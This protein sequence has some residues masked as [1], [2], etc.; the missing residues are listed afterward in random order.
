MNDPR[1]TEAE[2]LAAL[3]FKARQ[4]R[5]IR[6]FAAERNRVINRVTLT[7]NAAGYLPALITWAVERLRQQISAQADA[8]IEE[9]NTFKVPCDEAIEKKL[10]QAAS[11]FAAGSIMNV[12]NDRSVKRHM[13]GI[14]SPW[15]LEIE[16]EMHTSVKEAIAR[17]KHQS[18]TI[19]N[20]P[21]E[22]P[23]NQTF[24]VHGPNARVNID[25]IDNS[26]NI[27]NQG[28]PFSELRKA[29]ES[30]V[31]DGIERATILERLA[32]LEMATD[33]ES[34]SKRYQSFI[35]SAHHHMALIG[36]YLPALGH[37]VH[38]LLAAAI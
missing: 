36:P 4:E 5:I 29:I 24:N 34:G 9:F 25:S 13:L 11:D 31:T 20:R 7:Q 26:T 14:A 27:V 35:A 33:R 16:R 2:R 22:A 6:E 18:A 32:D 38:T 8:Y 37:W 15:H 10:W 17:L 3:T 21:N 12:R 30:G 23:M 28:I 1:R 19:R